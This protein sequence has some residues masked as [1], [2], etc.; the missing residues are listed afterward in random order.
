MN[1]EYIKKL[2]YEQA[3]VALIRDRYS[4]DDEFAIIR[5]R[6]IKPE[7]FSAYNEYCEICKQK[8]K[9]II[10]SEEDYE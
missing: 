10:E 3:V 7:E 2:P 1:C 6:E 9:E 5:Q 4:A 8:A